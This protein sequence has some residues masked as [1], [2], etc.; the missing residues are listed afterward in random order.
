MRGLAETFAGRV[1]VIELDLDDRDQDGL[2]RELGIT[3]QAQYVLV[4]AADEIVGRWWGVINEEALT[5]E[6]ET[7]LQT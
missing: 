3:A 1:D 2:R 5:S 4:N 6:L 7:L